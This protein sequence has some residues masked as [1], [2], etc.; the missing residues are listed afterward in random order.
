MTVCVAAICRFEDQPA[1]VVCMD[2]KVS[3]D[4]GS[5]ETRF[6]MHALA[7]E[8]YC[9]S[10]GVESEIIGLRQSI[11]HEFRMAGSIDETNVMVLVREA[12]R[13]RKHEKA[14][15]LIG[16][17]YGI[18]YDDFLK[19]GK[20]AFP[21]ELYREALS[22]VGR[23]SLRAEFIIAGF[24]EGNAFLCQTTA[25]G[26]V[27]ARDQFATIGAGEL[28][29]MASLLQREQ[30]DLTSAAMTVYNVYEAKKV[31]ER[32]SG[33]GTETELFLLYRGADVLPTLTIDGEKKL[34]DMFDKFGPQAVTRDAS[35]KELFGQDLEGDGR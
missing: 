34:D 35:L 25:D 12:L 2:R 8:W 4:V 11:E 20:D 24:Y 3:S 31:A 16:G 28:L 26:G 17:R 18:S 14:D 27:E 10:A 13:A 9:L 22:A 21:P 1:I 7:A 15:E 29:A 33:V 23:I 5:A 30:D 6:K 32:I 19:N